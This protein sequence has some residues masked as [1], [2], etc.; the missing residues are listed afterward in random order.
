MENEEQLEAAVETEQSDVEVDLP[1]YDTLATQLA[2]EKK[3][4]KTFEAQ[5][6]RYK[7]KLEKAGNVTKEVPSQVPDLDKKLERLELKT[8]GYSDQEIEFISQYGGKKALDNPI[9]KAA[10]EKVREEEKLAKATK[11]KSGGSS[12]KEKTYSEED[13]NNMPLDKLE[14]GLRTGK[15]K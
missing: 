2:E 13:L 11:I 12:S 1:D 8:E 5:K 9:L 7:E 3:R 4:S 14:E 15:I 10:I 6:N